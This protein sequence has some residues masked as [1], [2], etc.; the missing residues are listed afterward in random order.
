M[1]PPYSAWHRCQH[2]CLCQHAY[3]NTALKAHLL[4]DDAHN[5]PGI[6]DNR[7]ASDPSQAGNDAFQRVPGCAL[8]QPLFIG[9]HDLGHTTCTTN[10]GHRWS[11]HIVPCGSGGKNCEGGV[12]S[13]ESDG[14]WERVDS[15]PVIGV[16]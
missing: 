16:C 12:C 3:S 6:I 11:M 8:D 5:A 15:F 4:T 1:P 14:Q 13:N 2:A 7:H 10:I 9:T